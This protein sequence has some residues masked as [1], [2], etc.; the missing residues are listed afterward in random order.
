MRA[1]YH[2]QKSPGG[3]CA[4]DVHRLVEKSRALIPERV[5]LSA[6]RE[7]DQSYWVIDWVPQLTCREIVQHAAL[8]I[9]E[10]HAGPQPTPDRR[11][12]VQQVHRSRL[13]DCPA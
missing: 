6:I 5:P 1:Q 8:P 3:L 11:T 12:R 13:S 9:G 7:L 2:F 4:W 10:D